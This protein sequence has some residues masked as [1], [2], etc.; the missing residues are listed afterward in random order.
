MNEVGECHLQ[1]EASVTAATDARLAFPAAPTTTRM[2]PPTL[3]LVDL[4]VFNPQNPSPI[5][6]PSASPLTSLPVTSAFSSRPSTRTPEGLAPQPPSHTQVTPM[7]TPGSA[8]SIS[9]PTVVSNTG[10]NS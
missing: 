7:D 9:V 4:P 6:D 8:T 10:S 3:M 2:E 5:T 1:P